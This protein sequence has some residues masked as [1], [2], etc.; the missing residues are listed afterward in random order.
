MSFLPEYREAQRGEDV[1]RLRRALALRAMLAS[2]MSQRQIAEEL[3]IS[4]PA[5][6]Q[7]I[8]FAPAVDQVHPELLLEAAVPIL[9]KLAAEH[10]YEH[11]AVFGSAARREARTDSD[12]DLIVDAP[13]GTSSFAFIRFKQLI[14][15][16]LGRGID[17]VDYAGLKPGM[18]DDI[19]REAVLL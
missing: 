7:Q 1:A 11:L 4:Q 18:D 8:K 16:V 19:R 6:S 12:I 9:K 10:G 5:V 14:E 15:K 2:G 13:Q 17:L 3:G